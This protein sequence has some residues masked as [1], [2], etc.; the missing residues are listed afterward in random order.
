[1]KRII[2]LFVLLMPLYAY[3]Q[4]LNAIQNI[5]RQLQS[6]TISQDQLLQQAEAAGYDISDLEQLRGDQEKSFDREP[7]M[8]NIDIA[9]A[10]SFAQDTMQ[11]RWRRRM[12]SLRWDQWKRKAKRDTLRSKYFGY[13]LFMGREEKFDR[14]DIGKLDPNYQIGPG[15]E[16]IVSIWGET[17]RRM[18]T[19][20]SRDG[21]IFIEQY[22]QIEVSGL[23]L[24]Q[25]EEKLTKRLSTIYS[26]LKPSRGNPTTFLDV[27]LGELQSIQ[28]FVVGQVDQAGS[29]FVSSYSTAFSALYKA[30]GP[31]IK[32]SL[33]DIRVIRDGEVIANLDLYNF[34]TSGTMPE[35]IR[36]RNNDVVYVPPRI[37]KVRLQGEVKEE[38]FYELK[39]NETLRELLQYSGGIKRTADERH[40]QIE[41][42]APFKTRGEDAEVYK[43]LSVDFGQFNDEGEF[44]VNTVPIQDNDIVTVMPVTGE[45]SRDSVPGGVNFVNISGHV[46]KPGKYVLTDSMTIKDLLH[47]AGGLKDSI[48]WGETFQTRADLIRYKDNYLDKEIIPVQLDKLM[49][50]DEDKHNF[51]LRS[52]DSIIVYGADVV[53]DLKEVTVYGE[54][55]DT[56]RYSLEDNMTLQDLLLQ[57]G[58]FTKQA[59]KYN[60]EVFRLRNEGRD[61]D[62]VKFHDVAISPDILHKFDKSD[63]FELRDYDVVVVRKDPDFEPHR[64]VE[65]SGEVKFPGKY[66]ILDKNE[67]FHELIDRAGGLTDEAFMPGLQF[68]RNDSLRIVGNFD[69]MLNKKTRG[70]ILQEDDQ[71]YI[72]R[73]PGTVKVTGN[74]RNPGL[75]QYNE[76]WSMDNYI[77][78]AGDYTFD[79]AKSKTVVYY[80]GGNA[81]KKR[82]FWD[83]KVKEGSE[84]YVPERPERDINITELL[85]SWASIATN[86]ATVIYILEK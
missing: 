22:G 24:E 2:L 68:K 77:E 19:K 83:P 32:G 8:D 66:P 9:G 82:L 58:G 6:G 46:Y 35:D 38:S 14:G 37:S 29:Q 86:I 50:G 36:L 59:Y 7:Q 43:V 41:R 39:K 64:I 69:R 60:I 31:T 28:V 23:S 63:D 18:I 79:A 78:A 56:G 30:G 45:S 34:I 15:D 84:I 27:N 65:I 40:V 42:I 25:L 33:R 62:F 47:K 17:E 74:V 73:H 85:T 53:H 71:I 11:D 48:Y 1:M 72:P 13:D 49:E 70:I 5:A 4:D 54:V 3:S 10:P 51:L 76:N 55:K 61:E 12:D 44:E 20:V 21:T 52:R 81:R 75:V 16:I 57:A 67:T 26:G 80:P